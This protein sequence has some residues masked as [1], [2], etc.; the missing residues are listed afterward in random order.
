MITQVHRLTLLPH[1]LLLPLVGP[2]ITWQELD[3]QAKPIMLLP[4]VG[5]MITQR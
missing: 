1:H 5:P 2:M 3:N 4:L